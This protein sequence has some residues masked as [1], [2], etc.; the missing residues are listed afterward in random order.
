MSNTTSYA[1][2]SWTREMASSSIK[3]TAENTFPQFDLS[4]IKPLMPGYHIWDAW[5]VLN[6][7]DNQIADVY[8][9]RILVALGSK[10]GNPE[11]SAR[12]MYFVSQDGIHYA[13]CG[14][15]L[16]EGNLYI[17]DYACPPS[18]TILPNGEEWS[19]STVFREG[20]YIQTFYTLASGYQ[21]HG[22]WQKRQQFASLTQSIAFRGLNIKAS[23][24]TNNENFDPTLIPRGCPF[25]LFQ[26]SHHII[27]EPETESPYQTAES[28]SN[29]ESQ[30]PNQHDWENGDDQSNNFCFRD[31]KFV[32]TKGSISD[33]Y[34]FFEANTSNYLTP[35]GDN[36]KGLEGEYDKDFIGSTTFAEHD[37]ITPDAKRANACIGAM[38]LIN[39]TSSKT[40]EGNRE[41]YS[42]QGSFLLP[43]FYANFV[44][45]E[46]ER[47]NLIEHND[48]YYLFFT[49][50]SNKMAFGG[51]AM[52][53]RDMMI[54][55]RSADPISKVGLSGI[56]NSLIQWE[57][58]NG[59]GVVIQ[60]KSPGPRFSGQDQNH[61]YVYSWMVLPN[62]TVLCYSNFSTD[63]NGNIQPIKTMGPSVQLEIDGTT[64]RINPEPIYNFKPMD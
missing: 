15:L 17:D 49:T 8:G 44:S 16:S 62:L 61:Q 35:S 9:H 13:A 26:E 6:E 2:C 20:R 29:Y 58:L 45:D 64:T 30:N 18:N 40:L 37:D 56:V 52:V 60:Q 51:E 57:P 19:G 36:K 5:F 21:A 47:I 12:L 43:I 27:A 34:L 39:P 42:A 3:E 32:K 53:N 22:V 46:I 33:A 28:A 31:P 63:K 11:S 24:I 25:F 14:R 59:N 41:K 10:V 38:K 55:F 50:H 54:G 48:Y 1:A 4:Q 7:E 23:T